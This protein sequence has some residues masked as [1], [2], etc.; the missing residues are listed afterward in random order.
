MPMAAKSDLRRPPPRRGALTPV[1]LCPE[2]RGRDAIHPQWTLVFT[3][4]LARG[5]AEVGVRTARASA[6]HIEELGS[7]ER[8]RARSTGMLH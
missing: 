4:N 2:A 7:I 6:R 5:Y 3:S 1:H 8:R